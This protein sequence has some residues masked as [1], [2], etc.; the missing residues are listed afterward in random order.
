MAVDERSLTDDGLPPGSVHDQFRIVDH[1]FGKGF[2]VKHVGHFR[3]C[4]G[5]SQHTLKVHQVAVQVVDDLT[6]TS[7]GSAGFT[8]PILFRVSCE[9]NSAAP[10][11][12]LDVVQVWWEVFHD[13]SL[14]VILAT[15][16]F[17]WV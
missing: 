17:Q 12:W 7:I 8:G 16:P 6:G 1:L 15:M 11:E 10:K 14:E 13:P 2:D 4:H 9:Q 5:L 3:E